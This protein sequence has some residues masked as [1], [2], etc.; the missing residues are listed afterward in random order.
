MCPDRELV[1]AY[2]DGEVPSPWRERLEEHVSSCSDC[3][4]LAASFVSLGA[5]LRAVAEPGEAAAF[6]RGRAR[7]EALLAEMPA[8]STLSSPVLS[9]ARDGWRRSIRLPLPFAAAAALLVL[10]LGGATALL[11]SRPASPSSPIPAVA[12][13]MTDPQLAKPASMEELL[14]FL[15]SNEGPV[16]VTINLPSGTTFGSAGKPVIM[17]SNQAAPGAVL[18]GKAP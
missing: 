1:S 11:A 6:A 12:S 5:R 10:F 2:V 7:L 8:P 17:R 18:E 16:Q 3:A 15:G 9:S 14:R 13:G 4:A